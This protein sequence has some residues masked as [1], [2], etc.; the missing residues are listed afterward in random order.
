[1]KVVRMLAGMLLVAALMCSGNLCI[2][3]SKRDGQIPYSSTTVTFLVEVLK[4]LVMLAA[5][6]ATDTAP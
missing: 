4:L 6:V 3:A 2:S 5:I 1:M